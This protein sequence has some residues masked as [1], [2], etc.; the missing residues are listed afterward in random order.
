MINA[1]IIQIRRSALVSRSASGRYSIPKAAG[2]S[3]QVDP[4]FG[5][6][7]KSRLAYDETRRL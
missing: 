4:K 1:G 5:Y 2:S 7:S 3:F 6:S